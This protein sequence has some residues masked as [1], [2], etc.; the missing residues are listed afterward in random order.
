MNKL[1][2]SGKKD[3][4]AMLLPSAA[5]FE[6]RYREYFSIRRCVFVVNVDFNLSGNLSRLAQ[7]EKTIEKLTNASNT[8]LTAVPIMLSVETVR[9]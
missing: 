9:L 4:A 6:P 1:Y 7:H 8:G 2:I 3:V 5:P